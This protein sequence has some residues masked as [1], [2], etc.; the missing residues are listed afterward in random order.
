MDMFF[1]R[2]VEMYYPCTFVVITHVA[3]TLSWHTTRDIGPWWRQ[4]YAPFSAFSWGLH[5]IVRRTMLWRDEKTLM[6]ATK[7]TLASFFRHCVVCHAMCFMCRCL[8]HS[9]TI[10]YIQN[11]HLFLSLSTLT[12]SKRTRVL[13]TTRKR[14]TPMASRRRREPST[15]RHEEWTPSFWEIKN[16]PRNTITLSVNMTSRNLKPY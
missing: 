3:R 14:H 6:T 9:T 11:P 16:L 1:E 10:G 8:T 13:T 2:T 15:F 7:C 12:H 5:W 4:V